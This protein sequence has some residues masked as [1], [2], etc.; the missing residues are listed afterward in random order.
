MNL[1]TSNGRG[2]TSSAST[3]PDRASSSRRPQG[4][5]RDPV[6]VEDRLPVEGYAA[7]VWVLCHGLEEAEEVAGGRGVDWDLAGVSGEFG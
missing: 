4:T 1:P 5:L 7:G 3:R 2:S 6:R